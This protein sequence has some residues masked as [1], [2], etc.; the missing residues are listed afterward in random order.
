MSLRCWRRMRCA[1]IASRFSSGVP[2][3]RLL[4]GMNTRRVPT[5]IDV[6]PLEHLDAWRTVW[7]WESQE[8]IATANPSLLQKSRFPFQFLTNDQR[9]CLNLALG[10]D[11]TCS[12]WCISI[13]LQGASFNSRNWPILRDGLNNS[14]Y[15]QN[16]ALK[17]VLLGV[18]SGGFEADLLTI[19]AFCTAA[20]CVLHS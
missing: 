6:T 4:W 20:I 12:E 7:L 8:I 16:Y 2:C 11:H 17:R 1:L 18:S 14:K 5:S 3:G 13:K 10:N 9:L 15:A 19:T